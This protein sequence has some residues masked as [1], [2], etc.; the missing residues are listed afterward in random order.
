MSHPVASTSPA[1]TP[2]LLSVEPTLFV[3]DFARS[4]DYFTRVLGFAVAFTYGEP[5]FFGQVARGAAVLNLRLVHQP[6]LDLAREDDPVCL[7]VLVS[8]ARQLFGEFEAARASFHQVLRRE[9][10]HAEDHGG[11]IVR[12]PD[13]N[14]IGFAGRTD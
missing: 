6:V 10:W 4:L 13:G 1:Q 8:N 5:P 11:F 12:D 7:T 9:P 14:L 3:T 2:D